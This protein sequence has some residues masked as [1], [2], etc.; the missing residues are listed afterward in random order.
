MVSWGVEYGLMKTAQCELDW[1]GERKCGFAD[2]KRSILSHQ[3]CGLLTDL[4]Q[5]PTNRVLYHTVSD[6]CV[7]HGAH[8]IASD[9]L[10]IARRRVRTGSPT[11]CPLLELKSSIHMQFFRRDAST[12]LT[13][14]GV[15]LHSQHTITRRIDLKASVCMPACLRPRSVDA[16][17]AP[18][19]AGAFDRD[20]P[21]IFLC[22]ML[23]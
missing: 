20:M 8:Q 1:T 15:L 5:Y 6:W 14:R 16:V 2:M 3:A 9:T 17:L 21:S 12:L 4:D 10:E 22:W 13:D 19:G 7:L 18:I 11:P 23:I